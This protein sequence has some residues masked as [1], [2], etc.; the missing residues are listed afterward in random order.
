MAPNRLN[1]YLVDLKILNQK[2]IYKNRLIYYTI[3]SRIICDIS[4]ENNKCKY[5]AGKSIISR[6]GIHLSGYSLYHLI[7]WYVDIAWC[8]SKNGSEIRND[9]GNSLQWV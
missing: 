4:T 7:H 9:I 8:N 5:S 2:K 1:M 3:T 6:R